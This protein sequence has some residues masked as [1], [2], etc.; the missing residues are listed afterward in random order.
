[1]PGDACGRA[2]S[3]PG[4]AESRVLAAV[5]RLGIAFE[6]V[7][8]DPAYANTAAFCERYGYALH[9]SVNCIVVKSRT[10]DRRYAAC[11]VQA[12]RRLDVNRRIR[13]LLGV[14]KASFAPA[15]ETVALTGMVP[16]G[17]TP[18]GLPDGLPVWVDAEVLRHRQIIVGGG[19]RELKL[20]VPTSALGALPAAEVVEGLSRPA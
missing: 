5:E 16:D 9:T 14:R 13:G 10:G 17:V 18:F 1:M 12:T 20:L 8:I 6:V 15:E 3:G 7:R 11:C 2:T 19:S 4:S